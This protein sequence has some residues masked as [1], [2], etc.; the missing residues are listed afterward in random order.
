M[1]KRLLAVCAVAALTIG[2]HAVSQDMVDGHPDTYTVQRGDTL[3]DIAGRFLQKPWLWPEIWQANPQIENP[4]L[5]FPGDVISLA[6]LN[7][8]PQGTVDAGPRTSEAIDAIPL[9][10]VEDFLKKHRV[11]AS[12]DGLPYVVGLEEDRLRGA[13]G[14]AAYVRGLDGASEGQRL[15]VMRPSVR[16]MR[17]DLGREADRMRNNMLDQR[18]AVQRQNWQ[19]TWSDAADSGEGEFLGYELVDLGT[20]LVTRTS[21][22][23]TTI[24]MQD[25]GLE[26]REG[27]RLLPV[28]PQAFDLQFVPHAASGGLEARVMEVTEGY[29]V[30]GSRQVIALD[31]GARDGVDNGTVF[32]LWRDGSVTPDRVAGATPMSARRNAVGLPDEFAGHV[33]VFKT[34]DNVSYGLVMTT[35]RQVG[36]GYAAKHPDAEE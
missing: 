36:V 1:I 20:A 27:D 34:F 4:H 5:I 19:N 31:V 2:S 13:A 35:I 26:V 23:V 30:A 10:E 3:W 17:N 28:E 18:G 11:V 24:V 22:E 8:R 25:Q 16:Y 12:I 6:Y 33:M 32:S 9:S 21:A 29:R 15:R 14:Y 7:G